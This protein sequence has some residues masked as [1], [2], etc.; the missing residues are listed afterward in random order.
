[1]IEAPARGRY[2][3]RQRDE[4]D[5]TPGEEALRMKERRLT[6]TGVLPSRWCSPRASVFL[7]GWDGWFTEHGGW[8]KR[9][10]EGRW[11]KGEEQKQTKIK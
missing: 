4:A 3:G 7:V 2:V 9:M 1:M 5:G 8:A 10:T 6:D 11:K